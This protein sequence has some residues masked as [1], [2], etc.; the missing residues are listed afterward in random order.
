MCHCRSRSRRQTSFGGPVGRGEWAA[1]LPLLFIGT[2]MFWTVALGMGGWSLMVVGS[3]ALGDDAPAPT[4]TAIEPKP[5]ED[6]GASERIQ[7]QMEESQEPE[8]VNDNA[9]AAPPSGAT[10]GGVFDGPELARHKN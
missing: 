1:W 2:M 4:A 9:G 7:V 6:T 10:W 5:V 8:D 3:D